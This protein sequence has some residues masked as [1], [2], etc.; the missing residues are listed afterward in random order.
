MNIYLFLLFF[1]QTFFPLKGEGI[2]A[3]YTKQWSIKARPKCK[4]KE[5][6]FK[7]FVPEI[8]EFSRNVM[9]HQFLWGVLFVGST[10]P[11]DQCTYDLLVCRALRRTLSFVRLALFVS[12]SSFMSKIFCRI[13]ASSHKSEDI[14]ETLSTV[15]CLQFM[16]LKSELKYLSSDASLDFE[17]I[18][19]TYTF[20][21]WQFNDTSLY[22]NHQIIIN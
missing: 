7:G 12:I 2:K 8:P 4:L 18:N 16:E 19:A 6:S 9:G 11:T 13:S 22:N 20:E 1:K 15:C 21:F 17:N 5:A 14:R 10:L 3:R